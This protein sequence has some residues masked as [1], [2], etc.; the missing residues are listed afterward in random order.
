MKG[1]REV[2]EKVKEKGGMR[3]AVA[4]AAD[5]PVLCA[6]KD[7]VDMGLATADLVGD[8]AKIKSLAEKIGLDLDKAAIYHEPDARAAAL[9]AVKLVHDN[10]CSHL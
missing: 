10:T 8:E 7:A 3:I 6:V 9:K 2:F 1:F 4:A 5:E